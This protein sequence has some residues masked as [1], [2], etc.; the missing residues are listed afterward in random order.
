MNRNYCLLILLCLFIKLSGQQPGSHTIQGKILSSN[1]AS[2][3]AAITLGHGFNTASIANGNFTLRIMGPDTITVS[4]TGYTIKRIPVDSRTISPLT[5]ILEQST[6]ELDQVI[7]STGYQV[8]PKERATGSFVLVDSNL[9]NRSVSTDILSRLEGVTSGLLFNKN[10]LSS[11]EKTGIAIRGRS[12]IDEKVNANPLIIL[13]NFPYEGDLSNINPNDVENIT[14]LKDAAAAS[15]WGSRAGNG[16]IVITTKKGRYNEPLK[17]TFNS[18]LTISNKP[19]LLYSRSFLNSQGF[20]EIEQFLF[21]KGFYDATLNNTTTFTGVTP[22][23]EILAKKRN[24]QL[25]ATAADAQLAA[26]QQIDVRDDF[27]KYVY[28]KTLNQQYA[29][30]LRGGNNTHSFSASMGYD[31]NRNTLIRNGS[32]RITLNFLNSFRPVRGLEISAGIIYT[33]T[34][35]RNNNPSAFGA[36]S[37]TFSNGGSPYPYAK[38]ADANGNALPLTR[39]Y[40]DGYKDSLT[41]TGYLDWQY[42]PLDEIKLSDNT[43]RTDHLLLR[44]I[45]KYKIIPSLDIQLSYQNER[46]SSAN[47]NY[48]DV[49]T[50]FVRNLIN[51][52]YNPSGTSDLRKYPVPLGSILENNISNLNSD[53]LRLQLSF[54]RRISN[55]HEL[56][57]IAGAELKQ[58]TTDGYGRR[59]YGY[60]AEFGTATA[61]INYDSVFK[62]NPGSSQR[63]S[64]SSVGV[65]G[66]VNRFVSGFANAAYTYQKK[67]TLSASARQDGAN[68]FGVNADQRITP[69]GSVGFSWNASS[70]KFYRSTLLPY[71]RLRATY[72]FNGNVYNASAYLTGVYQSTG[73]NNNLIL[74]IIAPP[75][76]DLRWERVRNLNLGIDFHVR[77]DIISGSIDYFE[78]TGLD[79]IQTT[80]LA[81]STGFLDFKSNAASTR[82][83]GIDLMLNSINLDGPVKWTS[84]FLLNY[85]KDKVL[86]FDTKY[87]ASNLANYSV[88]AGT[89][90]G[91]GLYAVEGRSLFGVYSYRSAGIDNTGDPVGYLNGKTS[92]DY[93]SIIGSTPV[94]SLVY[95]GSSRPTLFGSLLNSFSYKRF[96]ISFNITYKLG[97][98]FR[99][100]STAI[101]YQDALTPPSI[102]ND[103]FL[104]WQ[105]PGDENI[106]NVPALL[107]PSNAN[108]NL[109]YRS[110]EVLIE[111]GDHIRL[112]NINLAY[113]LDRLQWKNMPFSQIQFYVYA[114]N[115]G[116]LWKANKVGVD[117]DYSA[118]Y[119]IPEPKSIS[120][121]LKVNL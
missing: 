64:S 27:E 40:R 92:K 115:L 90:A 121:G 78:K 7:V 32:D 120:V 4:H 10:N 2:L 108:R 101:N 105:K 83:R 67:Y 29:I 85:T 79:L 49:S 19:D 43:T 13:D 31:N 16:V 72:G 113:V 15:I 24:G 28:Q 11:N 25:S 3:D 52:F 73:L 1:G 77:K 110:S 116:I 68:I 37:S 109:F 45:A 100:N 88:L 95:S 96:S 89:V 80:T 47:R 69:L 75:N 53:N 17:V 61:N 102:S 38:L 94:D 74:G 119:S 6:R 103:Y 97:Y 42:R 86:K 21:N 56:T 50:Y 114:S 81:P 71:L 82:T 55:D 63:I 46:Q 41:A 12:T 30:N 60:N 106:T 22:V 20:I 35:T 76:A 57:I 23:V 118:A 112:Q 18:N 62:T 117:P 99:R 66:T 65:T 111:K 98:Y 54:D 44:A 36:V 70:E 39:G 58:I 51:Q 93:L 33:Q 8:I 104:R 9:L 14:V 26:L 87:P 48:M 5:I 84:T 59:V 34:N 91:S 107:Y